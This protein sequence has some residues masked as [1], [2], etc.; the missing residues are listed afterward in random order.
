MLYPR[1]LLSLL[2]ALSLAT[3]VEAI[4]L[5]KADPSY[6][7]FF[8]EKSNTEWMTLPDQLNQ[9]DQVLQARGNGFASWYGPGFHNKRTAS[10]ESFNAY[11]LTAAH[12]SLPMGT[13]VRV[14]NLKNGR[15]VI[16]RIND[17]GPALDTGRSIDLSQG[18]ATRIGMISSGVVPVKIEVLR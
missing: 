2:V 11:G 1:N 16:L 15:S 8:N 6:P 4:A 5:K 17:Y 13:R 10:G 3:P 14:T 9:S 18:A 12:R 7:F